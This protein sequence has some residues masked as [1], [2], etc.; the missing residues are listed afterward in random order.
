[1][2]TTI[3]LVVALAASANTCAKAF[4][5]SRVA[6]GVSFCLNASSFLVLRHVLRTQGMGQVQVVVSSGMIL[7]TMCIGMLLFEEALT[8]QR[9]VATI[10]ALLAILL[11]NHS[12][13]VMDGALLSSTDWNTTTTI[14]EDTVSHT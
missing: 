11:L 12:I 3:W 10:F 6:L 7:S 5:D 13:P 9:M 1:M 8:P 4:P 14:T 2:T